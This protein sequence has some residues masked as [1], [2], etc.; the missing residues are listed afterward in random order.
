MLRKLSTLYFRRAPWRFGRV[1]A[2][3]KY[4]ESA[5]PTPHREIVRT[6]FG[7]RMD[8]QT[9]DLVSGVIYATG[10]WEPSITHLIRERL[11]PGDVFV[12]V[13]ANIG[14]FSLLAAHLVGRS[15]RVYGIEASPGTHE[16][17]ARNVALNPYPQITVIHAAASDAPGTLPMYRDS[18]A[19]MGH[20][21]TLSDVA[22][23]DGMTFE[24]DVRADTLENLIGPDL[25][26][27]RFVK[28]DVEG[29]EPAV[30]RAL[31]GQ[32]HRFP[33]TDWLVEL[34]PEMLKGQ[35]E[36]DEIFRMFAA[37]GYRCYSMPNR[38][39]YDFHVEREWEPRPLI[40][41][42]TRT[43]DVVFTRT[44]PGVIRA[45]RF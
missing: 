17:F 18:G 23:R 36:V 11:R 25:F 45:R 32:L 13:G 19:N 21:T 9:P 35:A 31:R 22:A 34:S 26:R 8:L 33:A 3:W 30:F 2:L 24:A 20:S 4:F 7:A 6:A 14:Y 27:A 37:D 1:K 44:A 10:L 39:E 12:D 29:A 40:E 43:C 38:Y 41:P 28:V 16:R 5:Y 42:P 15:G